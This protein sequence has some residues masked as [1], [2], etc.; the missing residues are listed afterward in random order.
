MANGFQY[1]MVYLPAIEPAS[2]LLFVVQELTGNNKLRNY[3]S[4]S[5]RVLGKPGTTT[6]FRET[7]I[8]KT[9]HECDPHKVDDCRFWFDKTQELNRHYLS[10]GG[11]N[12]PKTPVETQVV[13]K[14]AD[15]AAGILAGRAIRGSRRQLQDYVNSC[16]D[17][18][19]EQI[20]RQLPA[21]DRELKPRIKW[22]SP[23]AKEGFREYRDAEFLERVGLGDSASHLASFWPSKGPCWDA[24]GVISDPAGKMKPGVILVEA[25][26][27]IA[28]IFGSGCQ[29]T[30][31]SRLKI[32]S[33]ISQVQSWYAVSTGENWLGPL[34]QFANRIAHLFFLRER[35]GTPTWL[36]NLYFTGDPIGPADR[37]EWE[38]AVAGVKTQ[39]GLTS[40][41]PGMVEVFL[42]ALYKGEPPSEI[43]S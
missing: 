42:P 23:L 28:E 4:G 36:V 27:H 19:S 31:R 22:V 1:W 38:I 26:S 5:E 30:P 11:G 12:S 17:A 2:Y 43:S 39:L 18:L 41:V 33:A 21:K 34:Y 20:L 24:L 9:R 16:P 13:V 25:K 6:V 10:V 3:A 15:E 8:G 7:Q 37:A 14:S 35:L 40:L 29:A 32:E